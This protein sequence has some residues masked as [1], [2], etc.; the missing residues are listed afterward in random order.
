MKIKSALLPLFLLFSIVAFSQTSKKPLKYPSLFWEIKAKGST[1]PSYLFGTMHVSSKLVYNLPDSFYI[2]LKN[3]QVVALEN[4]MAFWQQDMEKYDMDPSSFMPYQKSAVDYIHINT[5][6]VHKYDELI[7]YAIASNPSVINSL[8]YRTYGGKTA[9]FEEDTFLDMFIF[10]CGRKYGKKTTGLEDFEESMRLMIEGIRDAAKDKNKK[11]RSYTNYNTEY[12]FD[13]LEEAY[14]TGNLDLL[15]SIHRYNSMSELF[16]EKFIYRRNEIQANSIDSIIKTGATVFS[17][18]GAAHL[19]G[20]RGVIEMLRSKGYTVRPIKM[21]GRSNQE[22]EAVDKIAVPVTMK[23]ITAEDASYQVEA[24]GDFFST[25]HP[26]FKQVQHADMSNGSYYMITKIAT[27]ASM[28]GHNENHVLG[29]VDSLLYESIPGKILSKDKINKNGLPGFDI[30]NRTRRGDVQRYQVIATPFEVIIFKMSGI[31]NYVS[32]SDEAKHFFSSIQVKNPKEQ[33][34]AGKLYIPSSGGF[35]AAFP[36]EPFFTLK[37]KRVY[38]A[39]DGVN[40]YKVIV[41]SLHNYEEFGEDTFDLSLLEESFKA[42]EFI[43][44]QLERKQTSHKGY[45]ALTAKFK[46]KNGKLFSTKFILR[47]AHYYSLIVHS[48]KDNPAMEQFINSFEFKPFIYG[49]DVLQKDTSLYYTVTT[50]FYPEKKKKKTDFQELAGLFKEDEDAEEK[51]DSFIYR[52]INESKVIANDTTGERIEVSFYK[53]PFYTY[54]KDS[55]DLNE[56]EDADTSRIIRK[57]TKTVLADKTIVWETFLSDNGSSK[58]LYVKSF[59]KDGIVY[60]IQTLTDTISKPS[61]FVNR[62]YQTFSPDSTL[63]GFN[64]FEKKS[65][66]FFKDLQS[67]DSVANKRAKAYISSITIDSTDFPQLRNAIEKRNWKEKNYLTTKCALIK[68]VS[69]IK[70]NEAAKYLHDLYF[71]AGDTVQLQY[72]ALETLLRQQTSYSYAL[73]RDI[74]KAEPPVIQ[75]IER[76][77]IYSDYSDRIYTRSSGYG[78]S[79]GKFTDDLSDTLLL[80]KTILPDLL[81]LINL[82]D[83]KDDMMKLLA[84]MVEEEIIKPADYEIYFDKFLI[85]VKH[86]WRKQ[87]ITE[88]QQSIKKAEKNKE[89][90]E[91]GDVAVA[92]GDSDDEDKFNDDLILY[93]RLLIPFMDKKPEVKSFITQLLQSESKQL[94]YDVME[95]MLKNKQQVPDSLIQFFASKNEYRYTLFNDLKEWEMEKLFPAKY[96]NHKDLAISKLKGRS[97]YNTPD[98]IS[99]LKRYSTTINNKKGYIYFFKYKAKKDDAEWGLAT[100]GLVPESEKEIEFDVSGPRKNRYYFAEEGGLELT[101]FSSTKLDTEIPIEEQLQKLL[102]RIL[103]SSRPTGANFY[104]GEKNGILGIGDPEID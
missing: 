4:D 57:Q 90:E 60:S 35:A 94:K 51:E 10:Q 61:E 29:V 74:V 84:D 36:H 33:S 92:I 102:K 21:I 98:T 76:D 47:G 49:K 62:F 97:E 70:T 42:S 65:N 3:V 45:P 93:C 50:P 100:V 59:M 83:Y 89:D 2:G 26:L 1:K 37:D 56:D 30:V 43:D 96:R 68:R 66:Y 25:N 46:D 9:D 17:G 20:N 15:D 14:R 23:K 104:K 40:H 103:I 52:T 5:L 78:N 32:V 80:V 34:I 7:K 19:P 8:L 91:D 41:T 82:E 79:D 75:K 18:V 11:Q 12:S 6:K 71:I 85:E 77:Y 55:S 81:P 72:V 88:K 22:K 13:K 58:M 54:I 38:E 63:K 27:N 69:N 67:T 53:M 101:D 28:W 39:N 44:K 95:V 86:L 64:L 31:G 87:L 99:F 16:D 24:P 73:F 48:A